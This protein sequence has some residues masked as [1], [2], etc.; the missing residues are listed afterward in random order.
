M[1]ATRTGKIARLPSA[2]RE[3][4]NRRLD[5]GVS[6][7]ALV[8]WLN[9]LPEVQAIL[10]AQFGGQ[11]IN[12]VNLTKWRQGGYRDWLIEGDAQV[13]AADLS[14]EVA[15]GYGETGMPFTEKLAT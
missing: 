9:A 5:E 15:A 3:E 6:G 8:A 13:V 1:N 12:A 10:R 14:H 4:L 11:P 7:K 2:V